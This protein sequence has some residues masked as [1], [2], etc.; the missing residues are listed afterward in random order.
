MKTLLKYLL[1]F[2]LA[3]ISCSNHHDE[4]ETPIPASKEQSPCPVDSCQSICIE[5]NLQ[6]R[7]YRAPFNCYEWK[8][9]QN[10][11]KVAIL[12]N[13]N[14]FHITFEHQRIC[15]PIFKICT[16]DDCDCSWQPIE[17]CPRNNAFTVHLDSC[18]QNQYT[19]FLELYL[20]EN[21]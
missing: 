2:S 18:L 12:N 16:E 21:E 7:T 4:L 13:G 1:L 9:W 3:Y 20:I 10:G 8:N 19:L 15:K 6:E 17:D 5:L 11:V 14:T